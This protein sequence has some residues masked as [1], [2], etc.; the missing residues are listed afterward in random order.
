M[1]SGSL[2]LH[3][4]DER[5][6]AGHAVGEERHFMRGCRVGVQVPDGV[7]NAVESLAQAEVHHHFL[8]AS[9][10]HVSGLELFIIILIHLMERSLSK[11]KF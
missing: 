2:L 8:C 9:G 3:G 6:S 1:L 7:F 11:L 5:H 10:V 4:L